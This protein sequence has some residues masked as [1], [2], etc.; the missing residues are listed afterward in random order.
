MAVI[1]TAK[2]LYL[3]EE[4]D[5]EG[6]QV[7]LYALFDAFRPRCYPYTHPS[8]VCFAQLGGGL[9]SISCHIDVRRAS[10]SGLIRTTNILP[11]HFSNRDQLLHVVINIEGCHFESPG[12]I[13]S[14]CTAII[15]GLRT[16]HFYSGRFRN[17]RRNT[18]AHAQTFT[19]HREYGDFGRVH[20]PR[21]STR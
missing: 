11:L 15:H 5:V 3:C 16:Q 18:E 20:R 7:N 6:G 9:G 17:E 2:A 12:V 1:P 21:C 19:L 14:S 8:F 10:D 4:T 13:S